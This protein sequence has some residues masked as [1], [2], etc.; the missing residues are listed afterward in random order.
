MQEKCDPKI[1]Y[2][3]LYKK[4]DYLT[5]ERYEELLDESA[6]ISVRKNLKDDSINATSNKCAFDM[7]DWSLLLFDE[8]EDVLKKFLEDFEAKFSDHNSKLELFDQFEKNW[9]CEKFPGPEGLID[10]SQEEF[11]EI[12]EKSTEDEKEDEINVFRNVLDWPI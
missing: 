10:L 11:Y 7:P 12:W 4:G 9:V 3:V 5:V 2:K 1:S 6:I 8:Q